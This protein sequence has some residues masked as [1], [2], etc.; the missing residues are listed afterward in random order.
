MTQRLCGARALVGG[1]KMICRLSHGHPGPCSWSSLRG[2]TMRRVQAVAEMSALIKPFPEGDY[3]HLIHQLYI[4][5]R[6]LM[7]EFD[8]YT[9]EG[10]VERRRHG[11]D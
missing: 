1:R 7:I 5:G 6:T 4:N 8:A 10:V 9:Y 2:R 11:S 3:T